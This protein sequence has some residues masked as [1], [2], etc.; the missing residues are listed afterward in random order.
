LKEARGDGQT[1]M[2]VQCLLN[3]IARR[4]I[5]NDTLWTDEMAAK[6]KKN[7]AKQDADYYNIPEI[8]INFTNE[9]GPNNNGVMR[10]TF[11]D[12]K[13]GIPVT[14]TNWPDAKAS[15]AEIRSAVV[16]QS[17]LPILQLG[18]ANSFV[19]SAALSQ[20]TNSALQAVLLE[21]MAKNRVTTVR[22]SKPQSTDLRDVNTTPLTLPLRGN[23]SVIGH[24]EWKI[25][26]SLYLEAG[27]FLVDGVY[28]IMEVAQ[29]LSADGYTTDL[30]LMYN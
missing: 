18:H 4:F 20:I 28:K 29:K 19:K 11:H 22:D 8:V 14:T 30:V 16:A 27:I 1:I 15:Q 23:L 21:R 12:V 7:A 26:R 5:E 9:R 3:L 6:D 24:P 17:G 13:Q 10:V 2:T 25:F